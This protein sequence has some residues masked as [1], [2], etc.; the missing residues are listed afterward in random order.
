MH[1]ITNSMSIPLL[2]Y[3]FL[4]F[5][6]TWKI[7]IRLLAMNFFFV[8]H[9]RIRIA[10]LKMYTIFNNLPFPLKHLYRVI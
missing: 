6:I 3:L 2:V 4:I 1:K 10:V 9:S 8:I 5:Y 7:T